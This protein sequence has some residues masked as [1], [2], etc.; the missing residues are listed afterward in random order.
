MSIM[1]GSYINASWVVAH[2]VAIVLIRYCVGL[3][4]ITI[5]LD[6]R[7]CVLIAT[8]VGLEMAVFVHT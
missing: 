8:V 7:C 3:Y 6:S 5:L 2:H 1:M 4:V